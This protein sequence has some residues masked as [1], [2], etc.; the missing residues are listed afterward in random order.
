L[1]RGFACD[2]LAQQTINARR[3]IDATSEELEF[4]TQSQVVDTSQG[5][6]PLFKIVTVT[7]SWTEENHQRSVSLQNY[8]S[9]QN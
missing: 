6:A 3:G 7:V 9:W 1:S 8:V 2:D 4:K 5:G